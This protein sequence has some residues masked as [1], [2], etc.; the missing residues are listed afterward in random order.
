MKTDRN[1]L[2]RELTPPAGG[3]ARMRARLAAEIGNPAVPRA[4]SVQQSNWLFVAAGVAAMSLIA[5]LAVVALVSQPSIEPARG[6]LYASADFDRLLGRALTP[7][8][9][10][11]SLGDERLELTEIPTRDP[12]VRIVRIEESSVN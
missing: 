7:V 4:R 5:V 6:E 1:E 11:V 8:E 12:Q 9:L 10:S 2:F 3:A